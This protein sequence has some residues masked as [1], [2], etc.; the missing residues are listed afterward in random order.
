MLETSVVCR[1]TKLVS[2]DPVALNSEAAAPVAPIRLQTDPAAF[3]AFYRTHYPRALTYAF[4]RV[5]NRESA[6]EIV[7]RA[8]VKIVAAFPRFRPTGGSATAWVYRIVTNEINWHFR[9]TMR[10]KSVLME[11]FRKRRESVLAEQA[12]HDGAADFEQVRRALS[13]LPAKY[14]AVL[15]LR[16]FEQLA[17]TEIAE[18]LQVPESTVRTRVERGLAKLRVRLT[19]DGES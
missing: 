6:E 12:G 17:N 3:A 7:E 11:F 16:Y 15:S 13:L 2:E 14:A 5:G 10:Y 4:R 19:R 9:A 8:F 18:I 1:P